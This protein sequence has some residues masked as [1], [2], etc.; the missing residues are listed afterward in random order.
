M[1]HGEKIMKIAIT[2]GNRLNDDQSI[3]KVMELRLQLTLQLYKDF[4][5]DY[6]IVSGGVA[7][8]KAGVS[9]AAVM[10]QYLVK[11]G[12]P[13]EKIIEEGESMTTGENAKFSVKIAKDLKADTII[14]C[15]TIEHM[16]RMVYNPV[17]LFSDQLGECDTKLMIYTNNVL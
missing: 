14:V 9:E 6:I 13:E 5:I 10:K 12:I 11:N 15:T 2:L 17:K 4:D 16:T 3:T 8:K 7:N 1:N